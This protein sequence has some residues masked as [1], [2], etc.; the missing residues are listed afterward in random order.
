MTHKPLFFL[1]LI[2]LVVGY[3]VYLDYEISEQS[4]VYCSKKVK[5]NIVKFDCYKT[6]AEVIADVRGCIIS[7]HG[8]CYA[9][10]NG[11]ALGD[12]NGCAIMTQFRDVCIGTKNNSIF[13]DPVY[14]HSNNTFR[15]DLP[16][17]EDVK[18]R[19]NLNISDVLNTLF[20]PCENYTYYKQDNTKVTECL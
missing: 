14:L 7:V 13:K 18:E 19:I 3:C 2:P 10:H 11:E 20:I 4:K 12:N 6:K 15:T 17:I 8:Y 16:V 1:F 9:L 5:D